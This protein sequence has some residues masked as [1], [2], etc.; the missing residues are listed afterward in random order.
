MLIKN[1]T[2]IILTDRH[3]QIFEQAI[4]SAAHAEKLLIFDQETLNPWPELTTKLKN[5]NPN[6]E[7]KIFKRYGLIKD[8][9]KV[10]NQA[11]E[12]VDTPWLMFLDSD[13][14]LVEESLIDLTQLLKSHAVSAYT[15]HRR[16]IFAGK[17]MRFAEAGQ[18]RPIR[19]VKTNKVVYERR[20]HEIP[21]VTGIVKDSAII[22]D[23][24][25]HQNISEFLQDIGNY[26][27]LE[28]N[29]RREQNWPYSRA[30]IIFEAIFYPLAK[31]FYNYVG[32][33]GF[34]DGYAG[35]VYAVMMS[36]HSLLVRIYLYEQYFLN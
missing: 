16:D 10:R 28:A 4:L 9:A 21:K 30:K 22:I 25:A 1:L 13:E 23:H 8:F 19:L 33:L 14:V 5:I 26:A 24:L 29:Y 2:I 3:D 27:Q 36:L 12:M 34:L 17:K 15:V 32:E 20:V 31:F 35:F 7:I 11:L 18:N 6:L